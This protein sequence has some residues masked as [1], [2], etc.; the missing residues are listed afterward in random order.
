MINFCFLNFF[1]IDFKPSTEDEEIILLLFFLFLF[2][3]CYVLFDFFSIFPLVKTL[4]FLPFKFV[5]N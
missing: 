2:H 1:F 4:N 3:K 5:H